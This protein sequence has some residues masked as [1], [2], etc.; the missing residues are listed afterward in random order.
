M[1]SMD[2]LLANQYFAHE[3]QT[4]ISILSGTLCMLDTGRLSPER[5]AEYVAIMRRNLK[6]MQR[7]IKQMMLVGCAQQERD[8]MRP[9]DL[10][11]DTLLDAWIENA[12]AYAKSRGLAVSKRLSRPLYARCSADMLEHAFNNL[13]TNAIKYTDAGG[14][15]RVE[16]VRKGRFVEITIR[17]TGC[18]MTAEQCTAAFERH[19]RAAPPS[20]NASQSGFGLGLYLT[21]M[22]MEAMDGMVSCR[23]ALGQGS[24]F[25]MRLIRAENAESPSSCDENPHTKAQT[26][27]NAP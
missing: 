12:S 9:R 2:S 15:I 26:L 4:R 7:L 27:Q 23:S 25:T 20:A 8:F 22:L 16:A 18:G 14:S 1:L 19:R 5:L 3:I 6:D 13:F 17:D 11:I 24:A 10:R 21:R